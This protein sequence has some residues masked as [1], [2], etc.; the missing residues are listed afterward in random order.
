MYACC[1]KWSSFWTPGWNVAL[2]HFH[3][4]YINNISSLNPLSSAP[5]N[6]ASQLTTPPIQI[7]A[8][9]IKMY[10]NIPDHGG[11][12]QRGSLIWPLGGHGWE[13]KARAVCIQ[14]CLVGKNSTAV[15]GNE[16]DWTITNFGWVAAAENARRLQAMLVNL[17]ENT[18]V[19]LSAR[20][21]KYGRM[22]VGLSQWNFHSVCWLKYHMRYALK[23]YSC[24]SIQIYR[25]CVG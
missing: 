10:Q 18:G 25:W 20:V 4:S 5:L 24:I 2:C 16:L 12:S 3:A 15:V 19:E 11:P 17:M 23:I 7:L 21:W 13:R 6:L 22:W 9:Q 1:V 14:A 8:Q